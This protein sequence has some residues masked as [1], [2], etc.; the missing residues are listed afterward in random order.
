VLVILESKTCCGYE[1]VLQTITVVARNLSRASNLL[2]RNHKII[3]Q[4]WT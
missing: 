1:A 3:Q 2:V 4:D